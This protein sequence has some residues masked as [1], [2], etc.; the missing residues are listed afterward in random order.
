MP[1]GDRRGPDGFGPMTG[2][3]LGY[4]AGY[5]TPGYMAPVPGRGGGYG[6]GRGMAWR[7]GWGRAP[8]MGGYYTGGPYAPAQAPPHAPGYAP[9]YPPSREQEIA[10]LKRQAEYF[11]DGLEAVKARIEELAQQGEE[12]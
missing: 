12:E 8:Y 3:G 9:A 5:E 7:R 4:C 6:Y 10:A 11:E 2:R 1:R